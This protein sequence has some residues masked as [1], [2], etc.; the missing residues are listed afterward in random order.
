M[1]GSDD[2]ATRVAEWRTLLSHAHERTSIDGG[3]RITFGDDAPG[4]E[5]ARLASAERNCCGFFAFSLTL[6][7][8][9]TALEVRTPEDGLP[10]LESL[11]AS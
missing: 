2:V 3:L 4:P 6:D 8:R 1:L 5:I 10:V 7:D 9:G 11:F